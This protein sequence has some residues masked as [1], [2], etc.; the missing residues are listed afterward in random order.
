MASCERSTESDFEEFPEVCVLLK[1]NLLEDVNACAKFVDSVGKVVVR[2]DS[3]VK[4][5]AYSKRFSL[6]A[7]M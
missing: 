3:F 6:F 5:P 4:R 2:S 1:A 7:T